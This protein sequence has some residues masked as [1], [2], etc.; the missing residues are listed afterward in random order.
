MCAR[1]PQEAQNLLLEEKTVHLQ[2]IEP[3]MFRALR[4]MSLNDLCAH[5]A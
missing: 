2:T 3:V 5:G 1:S 4:L